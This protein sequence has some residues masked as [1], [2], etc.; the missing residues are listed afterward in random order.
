MLLGRAS[1]GHRVVR[2]CGTQRSLAAGGVRSGILSG[3]D[4]STS[5]G[6]CL[7]GVTDSPTMAG[8]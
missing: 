8:R 4:S 5:I 1:G 2:T 7:E 6:H 3:I